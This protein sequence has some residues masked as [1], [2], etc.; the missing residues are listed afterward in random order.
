LIEASIVPVPD[1]L[2]NDQIHSVERDVAQNLMYQ[3]RSIEEYVKDQ[4]F[5]SRDDWIKNDIEPIARKRVQAGLVLAE[6]SK[7]E[8]I[9]AIVEDVDKQIAAYKDQYKNNPQMVAEFNKPET[10]QDIA[11]R[12]LTDKAVEYLLEINSK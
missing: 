12:M 2:L 10:R 9:T 5:S 8:S 1:V 3:G 4:G 7:A 6:L 11:S